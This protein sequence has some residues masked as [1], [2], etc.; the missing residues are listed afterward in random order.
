MTQTERTE[1]AAPPLPTSMIS[2]MAIERSDARAQ[3]GHKI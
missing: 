1:A 2:L 3:Q